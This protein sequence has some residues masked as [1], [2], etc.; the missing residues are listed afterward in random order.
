MTKYFEG[1]EDAFGHALKDRLAGAG[2][3]E[4]IE[5]SD[6]YIAVA[7]MD[8]DDY[9]APAADWPAHQ[10]WAAQQCTGR[11][12]D[13]GAG[14]GR[15]ALHLQRQGHDVVAI[16][17]SLGA[18]EVCRERG[19]RDVRQLAIT[20]VKRDLGRFDTLLMMGNNFGLFASRNRAR[21]LL[22][23]FRRITTKT[24]RI[25]TEILD[26]Y[27]TRDPLHFAY[28]EMNR[29]RG[30]MPGQIRLRVR[31]KIYRTPWYDYLFVSQEELR[32]LI[33]GTGW[34]VGDVQES[35]G[36]SYVAVLEKAS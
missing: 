6:G 36:P 28:Q 32:A 26:P 29:R 17:A 19:V 12:L 11:V 24:G 20:D 2:G 21:K 4:I 16:D 34:F 33:E 14:A 5:R 22:R 1:D 13:I 30:R 10:Q 8:L 7:S 3:I 15:F 35:A 27:R 18:V 9:F 31:Y 23:R 25:V